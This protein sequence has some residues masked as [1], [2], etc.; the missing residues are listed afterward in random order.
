M[1]RKIKYTEEAKKKM[2]EASK[3]MWKNKDTRAKLIEA[4]NTPKAKMNRSKAAKK[5]RTRPGANDTWRTPEFRA[6]K[7]ETAKRM[8]KNN[9]YREKMMKALSKPV[10][11]YT[12]DGKYI[13]TYL[14]IPQATRQTGANTVSISNCCRGII[15]Y[16]T[17]GGFQWRY[18]SGNTENITPIIVLKRSNRCTPVNQYTKDGKYIRTFL[19]QTEAARYIGANLTNIW[20]C[21]MGKAK[22]CRGFQW[23]LYKGNTDNIESITSAPHDDVIIQGFLNQHK[24]DLPKCER[25]VKKMQDM[26]QAKKLQS[27]NN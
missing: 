20:N 5:W 18:Y 24:H 12:R 19:S 9:E 17:A 4:M 13:A 16:K 2:S 1:K 14:S 23:Q 27:D 7:S 22:S 3:R 6:K 11:Q 26:I 10:N 15:H 25:I 8:W 21:C